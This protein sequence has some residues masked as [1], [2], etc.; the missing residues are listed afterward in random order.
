MNQRDD[1]RA[2]ELGNIK[3]ELAAFAVRLDAFEAHTKHRMSMTTPES[4]KPNL[5]DT[6]L[7]KAVV[8]T[9]EKS[10]LPQ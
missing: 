10:T 9:Q 3:L 6:G 1:Q 5:S 2:Q 7:A 4:S 8:S